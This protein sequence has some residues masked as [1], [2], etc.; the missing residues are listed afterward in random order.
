MILRD[1]VTQSFELTQISLFFQNFS[2]LSVSQGEVVFSVVRQTPKYS[3]VSE[4]MD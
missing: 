3:T 4:K 2:H 1:W